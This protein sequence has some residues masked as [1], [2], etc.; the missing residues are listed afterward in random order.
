MYTKLLVSKDLQIMKFQLLFVIQLSG[1]Y[2]IVAMYIPLNIG[3]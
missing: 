1:L 3:H 2:C